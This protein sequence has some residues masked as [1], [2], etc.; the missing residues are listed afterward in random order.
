MIDLPWLLP[1][2]ETD[3][4]MCY[5]NKYTLVQIAEII[6]EITN[7]DLPIV[8]ENEG[9]APKYTGDSSKVTKLKLNFK[10]LE[11]GIKEMYNGNG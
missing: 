11:Q 2:K 7:T 6:K 3:I 10:G 9:E 4:N 1:E 8:V 5:E